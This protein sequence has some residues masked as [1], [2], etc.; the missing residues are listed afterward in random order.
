MTFRNLANI[1]LAAAVLHGCAERPQ[2]ESSDAVPSPT[3]ELVSGSVG[4][5]IVL[6]DHLWIPGENELDLRVDTA[7]AAVANGELDRAAAELRHAVDLLQLQADAVEEPERERIVEASEGLNALI[8]RLE[9]GDAPP[10]DELL[11]A[12]EHAQKVNMMQHWV[13]VETL[14]KMPFTYDLEGQFAEARSALAEDDSR[15]AAQVL[16]SISAVLELEVPTAYA[17]TQVAL[18]GAAKELQDLADALTSG[19]EVPTERLEEAFRYASTSVKIH[20]DDLAMSRA[21]PS[22][23][24]SEEQATHYASARL[25]YTAPPGKLKFSEASTAD[26]AEARRIAGGMIGGSAELGEELGDVMQRIE[27]QLTSIGERMP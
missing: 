15:R 9:V 22:H 16:G 24:V 23:I 14:T 3:E 18:Q 17:R 26:L 10:A 21:Q 25:E 6:E 7:R 8:V 27:D 12:C 2:S 13:H 11:A 1:L 20:N 4:R 5:W 19:E